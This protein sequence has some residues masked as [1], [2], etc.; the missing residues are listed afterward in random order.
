MFFSI[1]FDTKIVNTEGKGDRLPVMFLIARGS[2][3]LL[4]TFSDQPCFEQLLC[5]DAGLWQ[6]MHTFLDA[7]IDITI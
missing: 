3:T 6:S 5:N 2:C 4:V 7:D 1:V